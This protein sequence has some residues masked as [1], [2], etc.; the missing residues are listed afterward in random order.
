MLFN[1]LHISVFAVD[2][3]GV[4]AL[5]IVG[6]LVDTCA[7]SLVMLEILYIGKGWTITTGTL[8]RKPLLYSVW[9]VYTSIYLV[10]FAFS[11]VSST[12]H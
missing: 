3:R 6:N 9:A 7:Q 8:T 5:T 4:P 11:T 1:L 2:G 12:V 10:L